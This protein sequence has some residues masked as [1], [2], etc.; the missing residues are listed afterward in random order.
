MT[1]SQITLCIA[2]LIFTLGCNKQVAPKVVSQDPPSTTTNPN[3]PSTEDPTSPVEDPKDPISDPVVETKQ[4]IDVND[5]SIL[6]PAPKSVQD[7]STLISIDELRSSIDNLPALSSS[8]FAEMV[9][10]SESN[11]SRVG[12]HKIVFTDRIRDIGRWKIA[13]IR[14]DPT[15]PG[16]SD[17]IAEKF[18]RSPQI[19]LIIQPITTAGRLKVHDVTFHL[20]Y[21]YAAGIEDGEPGVFKKV[22]PDLQKSKE[23]LDD[24]IELKQLCADAGVD[25]DGLLG[26]HPGLK[27]PSDVPM[28]RTRIKQFLNKHLHPSRIT[29]AAVM[30]LAV[31]GIEPW[32]FV[33][34]HHDARANVFSAVPSPGL[35]P[36][37][38]A[39]KAQMLNF[40]GGDIIAPEPITSNLMPMDNDLRIPSDTRFGVSTIALFSNEPISNKAVTAK[41]SNGEIF[42]DPNLRNADVDD[43]VANPIRSHFFNTDCVS[44]HTEST[45]RALQ[46]G[47]A[48]ESDFSFK[49]PEGVSGVQ[50]SV[51]PTS[52]YNVRNFGWFDTKETVTLRTA[53]ETAEV[54]EF[55]NHTMLGNS[56]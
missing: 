41:R 38:S 20:M 46:R 8:Q 7:V 39:P 21:T 53:N 3:T 4:K 32:I 56:D 30:G 28:L 52:K 11:D 43:W 47:T 2:L 15:A 36:V 29:A 23:I 6:F 18:G 33:A 5:V 16:G 37:Q 35:G 54:V 27:N 19:R 14:F 26:V 34:M 50:K 45:R 1:R 42:R 24:L 48:S 13:G 17:A 44:C 25:T 10:I 31:N 22:I 51:L 9:R 49:L 12:N 40:T 55:I